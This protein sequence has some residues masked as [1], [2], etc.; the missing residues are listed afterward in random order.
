VGREKRKGAREGRLPQFTFLATPLRVRALN[1]LAVV[2][3]SSGR[4]ARATNRLCLAEIAAFCC[5][6]RPVR[7]KTTPR[8]VLAP[9]GETSFLRGTRRKL[10]GIAEL[11]WKTNKHTDKRSLSLPEESRYP[12]KYF[13]TGGGVFMARRTVPKQLLCITHCKLFH[14]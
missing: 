8:L 1:A 12:G 14:D 10:P 5:R 2:A 6:F 9:A 13:W 4:V 3:R 7:R 11:F